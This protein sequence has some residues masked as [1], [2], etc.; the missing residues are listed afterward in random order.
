MG[1]FIRVQVEVDREGLID[2][3]LAY[4]TDPRPSRNEIHEEVLD[5]G[6]IPPT[7]LEAMLL[8]GVEQREIV[9]DLVDFCLSNTG[10][11]NS[12]ARRTL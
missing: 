2:A 7:L 9:A 4:L 10:L 11:L 12:Y 5:E 6:P 3:Y 1:R 8:E